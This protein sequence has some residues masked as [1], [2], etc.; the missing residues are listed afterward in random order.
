VLYATDGFPVTALDLPATFDLPEVRALARRHDIRLIANADLE[1]PS[2][3][4]SIADDTFDVV[5]FTEVIE[6]LA[7]NPVC[8]WRALHRV[9]K[10][11]A[12]IVVTTPNYYGL[13]ARA[14]AWWRALR[15][16][17]AGVDVDQLLGVRTFGHHWKEYS[18]RELI[19]YFGRLSSDFACTRLAYTEEYHPAFLSNPRRR[20][21][22]WL[23]HLVPPLRPDLYLEVELTR[24][25]AGIVIEPHW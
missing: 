10:P 22:L 16:L 25:E 2:A 14:H 19:R 15:L 23:E 11:R 20:P 13:R 9:M 6:H 17:G 21:A 8:M 5:L 18:R 1:D 12:V 4:E 3:L 24:K 7:F